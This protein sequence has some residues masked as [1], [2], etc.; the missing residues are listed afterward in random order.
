MGL[1]D[2]A[3]REHL[4]LKRRRGADPGEIAR[5]Q[6]EVLDTPREQ[7]PPVAEGW[8]VPPEASDVDAETSEGSTA[9]AQAAMPGAEPGLDPLD[10]GPPQTDIST[11]GEETAELDMQAVLD[12]EHASSPD[13]PHGPALTEEEDE[14]SD[15]P[16]PIPGQERMPFE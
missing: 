4:E 2:D 15:V 6:H 8:D 12:G 10:E 11:I 16:R 1:L 14:L 9:F 3:I 5:E 7:E 13:A